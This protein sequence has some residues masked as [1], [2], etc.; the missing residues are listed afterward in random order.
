M[1]DIEKANN[2]EKLRMKLISD[3]A[4]GLVLETCVGTNRNKKFY[5]EDKITKIIGIDWVGYNIEKAA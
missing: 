1:D 3:N 2:I 5:R 4:T